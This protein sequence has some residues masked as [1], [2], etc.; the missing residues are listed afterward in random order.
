MK[1][2]LYFPLILTLLLSLV[3]SCEKELLEQTNP[4]A[5]TTDSYWQSEADFN[6]ALNAVYSSLQFNSVYGDLTCRHMLRSDF[7]G[8]ESWYGIFLAYSNFTYTDASD[9]VINQWSQLY[10]GIFRANQVLHYLAQYEDSDF[11]DEERTLLEA[12]VRFIRGHNYFLLAHTYNGAVV[13]TELALSDEEITKPFSSRN[14]VISQVVIPDL[15]F[16]YNNL[17]KEWTEA[18]RVTW[19]AAASMLG[20]T[21]L[22]DK[23]WSMAADYFA[24][25]INEADNNGLYRLVD[26]YF[27]NFTLE[28]EYN[29]ES[30]FEIGFTDA[31]KPGTSGRRQDDIPANEFYEAIG[32][33][34]ANA[35]PSN[36]SSIYAGGYNTVLPT[37]WLQEL[38]VTGDTIDVNNPVNIGNRYSRRA[39]A[40]LV[41]EFG[42]G[43]Y[44]G[45]PLRD[46][47][48]TGETSKANFNYGQGS[49]VRKY[50]NWYWIES[51]DISNDS[52]SGINIRA[53]RLADIYLMYA[54]AILERDGDAAISE[55]MEYVDRLRSR[56][57]TI[58]LQ[59]YMN[60]N[61]GRIP[62][63]HKSL[64]ANGFR[65]F[66]IVDSD[67]LLTH[68]RMVE[69]PLEL[70]FEGHR[71]Y[72]LVRWGNIAEVFNERRQEEISIEQQL[73]GPGK[74]IDEGVKVPPLYL[75]ERVR[76][77]FIVPAANYNSVVHDYFPVPSVE[78]QTN[79]DLFN[80]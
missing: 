76:L 72:D 31:Y 60:M 27:D 57:G 29:S 47:P 71:W 4:N 58:T 40:T 6:A 1:R 38:F 80:N 59:N 77:D 62:L 43:D 23:D 8:T 32:G 61:S 44:Y 48:I 55:A 63:L 75:N 42:D 17:P 49:K 21:Y 16:A 26:D 28:G 79:G 7:S 50:T 22:Y 52:R 70:A 18:G 74:P 65:Q 34:E 69:R 12:Q 64:F 53:I 66:A 35:H 36:F 68:I 2:I 73:V 5:I 9:L 54:E 46:N 51:E 78:L 10:I 11:T 24:E 30:I 13:H 14:D 25:V 39:Y 45:A 20:K 67:V 33:S 15:E 19:G 37:Y 3:S 56:A 41:V